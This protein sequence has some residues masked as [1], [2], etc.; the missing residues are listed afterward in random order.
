MSKPK[1]CPK[2]K[3]DNILKIE[4]GLP[5]DAD[6]DTGVYLGGCCVTDNDPIWHCASCRWQWGN[7]SEGAYCE[8][9]VE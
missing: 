6:T 4:Y 1:E 8:D 9:D 5:M 7:G 3:S 2:C